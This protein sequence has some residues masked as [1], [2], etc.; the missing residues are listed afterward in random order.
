MIAPRRVA[1][2]ALLVTLTPLVLTLAQ[3]PPSRDNEPLSEERI[4]RLV[5]TLKIKPEV[6]AGMVRKRGICFAAD[7]EVL[8]RLKKAKVPD[9]VLNAVRAAGKPQAD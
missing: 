6:V 8:E 3:A 1:G 4:A 5:T 9:V 7:A 2:W